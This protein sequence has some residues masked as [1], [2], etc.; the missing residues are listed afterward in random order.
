MGWNPAG[1]ALLVDKGLADENRWVVAFNLYGCRRDTGNWEAH[2][3]IKIDWEEHGRLVVEIPDVDVDERWRD[4]MEPKLQLVAREFAETIR[5]E[6]LDL[7][8]YFDLAPRIHASPERLTQVRT[9][10]R[11][12]R[13]AAPRPQGAVHSSGSHPLERLDEVTVAMELAA[14]DEE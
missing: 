6:K 9:A 5:E 7:K 14:S 13:A 11:S 3:W 12:I 2:V 1:A 10:L 8:C 4:D